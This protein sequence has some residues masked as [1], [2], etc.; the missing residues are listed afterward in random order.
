MNYRE[1]IEEALELYQQGNTERAESLIQVIL[2][3]QPENIQL[4]SMIGFMY[5]QL[6]K[7]ESAID[8]FER[9]LLLDPQNTDLYINLGETLYELG[10]MEEAI[11]N[12]QKALETNPRSP[13]AISIQGGCFNTRDNSMKRY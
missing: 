11:Q 7:A 13:W 4:L 9:A 12:Y 1:K 10:R 2:K 3:K 5:A 8:Y 6:G